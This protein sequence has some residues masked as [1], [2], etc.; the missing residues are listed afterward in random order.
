MDERRTR[1]RGS[2]SSIS[3]LDDHSVTRLIEALEARG[4]V[5]QP[6][7]ARDKW[8]DRIITWA[9]AVAVAWATLQ[10]DM[11]VLKSR[12]DGQDQLLNEIRQDIKTLLRREP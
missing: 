11:A 4:L 9:I 1:D 7:P 2:P 12:V 8:V 5:S 6:T 10:A 3:P